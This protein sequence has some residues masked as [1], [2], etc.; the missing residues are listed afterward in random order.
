[1]Q[2]YRP[3]LH[4]S[5]GG[6]WCY[7]RGMTLPFAYIGGDPALDLVNTV[8]W[9]GAGPA[10]ERLADYAALVADQTFTSREAAS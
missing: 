4:L 5:S 3:W 2:R 10:Q 1:M 9:T 8:D 7:F 6:Y